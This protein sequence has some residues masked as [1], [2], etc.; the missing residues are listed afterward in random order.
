MVYAV[1]FDGTLCADK[2]PAI[3]A[4]DLNLIER[5]KARQQLGD[6]FILWTCRS[7]ADLDAALT[8]CAELGLTFDAVN[9]NLSEN[10]NRHGGNNSRKVCADY[11]ID[12]RNLYVP[13][14]HSG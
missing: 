4:P 10:L 2:Y 1:D 9:D 6:K 13:L 12:D 3:G 14:Q 11:Y 7:G 5:I 8:W